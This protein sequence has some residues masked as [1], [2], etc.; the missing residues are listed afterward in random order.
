MPSAAKNRLFVVSVR[1]MR[2]SVDMSALFTVL[3][4]LNDDSRHD[5]R[6]NRVSDDD[7]E[8]RVDRSS[9]EAAARCMMEIGV[10]IT[11]HC[12]NTTNIQPTQ[13]RI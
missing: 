7:D 5:G 3:T 4:G 9:E 10:A 2:D 8:A 6:A 12:I 13:P 11:I 1:G